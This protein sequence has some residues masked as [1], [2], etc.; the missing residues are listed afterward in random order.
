[1]K[2]ILLLLLFTS[3]ISLSQTNTQYYKFPQWGYR[4]TVASGTV[5]DTVPSA[6]LTKKNYLNLLGSRSEKF[7]M[8]HFGTTW[9][10]LTRVKYINTTSGGVATFNGTINVTNGI[11]YSGTPN[12][13]FGTLRLYSDV[14]S[15]FGSLSAGSVGFT[16]NRYYY[17]V[18]STGYI[19]INAKLPLSRD[20]KGTVSVDTSSGDTSLSTRAY[21]KNY[22]SGH[23]EKTAGF[24]W[25]N[26][27]T[28]DSVFLMEFPQSAIVDSFRVYQLGATTVTFLPKRNH[29]GT[30]TDMLSE[31]YTMTGTITTPPTIQNNTMQL[32]D[33]L[34]LVLR[35][36]TGTATSIYVQVNYHYT[37]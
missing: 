1:M 29:A 6:G 20:A 15:Y 14:G 33:Q 23:S 7:W 5:G 25:T 13:V 24:V 10:S 11:L 22:F 27:S 30:L 9:D 21:V 35:S 32:N 18:D 16:A 37:P 19:V 36:I 2:R 8:M 28:T 26:Q 17:A 12:S 31:V 3:A 34:F 4:D